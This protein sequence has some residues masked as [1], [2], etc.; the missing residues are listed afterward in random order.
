MKKW[1]YIIA[2]STAA[3]LVVA[4]ITAAAIW[5]VVDEVETGVTPEY[6]EV[7]PYYYS[8]DPDRI[9][10]EAQ[11]AVDDLDGWK[12]VGGE[13]TTRRVEATR[14]VP[15]FGTDDTVTIRVEPVTEFVAQV[16]VRSSS[17]LG[18]ADFGRNA[19]NIET[20]FG[21]LD[22]RLGS[23]R[24]DPDASGEEDDAEDAEEEGEMQEDAGQPEG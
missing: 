7:Q 18:P 1:I 2:S 22:Q 15:V 11:A 24:F 9:Y 8:T 17:D 23:V 14:P 3:L 21:E 12:L 19:R 6:P 20:F 5:P 16:H 4:M 13:S 10:D